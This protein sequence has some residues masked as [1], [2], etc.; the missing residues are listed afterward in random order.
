M[1]TDT[2]RAGYTYDQDLPP[3]PVTRQR[4]DELLTDVMWAEHDAP[5]L[6]R[7]G[8]ILSP[9]VSELLDIW[10]DFIG[11]T[12]HL[13]SVF[14]GP[15]GQPNPDYLARV[16]A[17]FE[18]WVRD[19]CERNFDD[20]WLAYQEEIGLRHH[21][22]KKNQ[23]DDVDSPATHVPMADM[24]ALVVPVTLSVRPFLEEGATAED[25]VEAMNQAW[26]KAVTVTLV[27][28]ARPYAGQLW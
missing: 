19:V 22:T 17:R 3:S 21:T 5:A 11:S 18:Q 13:V 6:R 1:T 12:P 8:E 23:T 25:D 28:W 4:L 16:R 7:A 24:L 26:F 2:N 10:Y 15:D 14:R 27:L 20:R 9:R